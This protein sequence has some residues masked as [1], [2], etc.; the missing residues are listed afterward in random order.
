MG[1]DRLAHQYMQT[2]WQWY[3]PN[4]Y[5]PVNG[6]EEVPQLQQL[7][8][9]W[10]AAHLLT[11]AKDTDGQ[12]HTFKC[13][14]CTQILTRV[15][16]TAVRLRPALQTLLSARFKA[17]PATSSLLR[18]CSAVLSDGQFSFTCQLLRHLKGVLLR[19][20]EFHVLS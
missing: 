19:V 13:S 2:P 7:A 16:V 12:T 3:S 1:Q 8:A 10:T 14:E 6:S 5:F 18:H 20:I 4:R 15:T 17:E 9:A 11:S